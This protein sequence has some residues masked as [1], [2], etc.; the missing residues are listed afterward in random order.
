VPLFVRPDVYHGPGPLTP[1]AVFDH[2]TLNVPA[3]LLVVLLGG[4][5]LFGVRRVRARGQDWPAQRVAQ[6]L[7]VGLLSIVLATMSFLGAYDDTLFW[8]RAATIILLLMLGPYGLAMSLP[9]T[10]LEATLGEP[11]RARLRSVLHGRVARVV[12]SPPITS[13][14]MMGTPW[15]L[16]YSGYYVEVL[17]HP[18]VDQLFRLE[19]LVTGFLYVY[20][21]M[22][23]D[24]V[25]RRYP[26]LV[27]YGIS[28]AEGLVDAVLGLVLWLDSG[29]LVASGY[30]HLLARP[31]GPSLRND[32]VIGAGVIWIGGDLAGLPFLYGVLTQM[33][34]DDDADAAEVDALLDAEQDEREAARLTAGPAEEVVPQRMWWE[35]HP[36]LGQRF[37]RG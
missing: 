8:V 26:P 4:A 34:R 7:L 24:L 22:Q 16:Y 35:D 31:W 15:A 13:L 18:V 14:L 36:D 33:R 10:L 1:L 5:Y 37:R 30:Y 17:E 3:L 9:V 27:A 32:Q 25:P 20:A 2:W 12:T 29:H 19:L 23:R 11:G 21:R 28:I 6:F